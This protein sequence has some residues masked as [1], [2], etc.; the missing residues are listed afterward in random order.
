MLTQFPGRFVSIPVLN[1][2][3]EFRVLTIGCRNNRR[4]CAGWIDPIDPYEA[5]HIVHHIIYL[6]KDLI[7]AARPGNQVVNLKIKLNRPRSVRRV[8]SQRVHIA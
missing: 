7:V 4:I 1:T 8:G 5:Q 3:N 2:L 6:F